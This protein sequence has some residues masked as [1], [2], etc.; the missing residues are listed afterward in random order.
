MKYMNSYYLLVFVIWQPF[1]GAAYS[2]RDRLVLADN[3]W[4]QQLR[5]PDIFPSAEPKYN[6]H[7]NY[8]KF[9]FRRMIK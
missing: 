6:Q 1:V 2:Q 4:R 9:F 8:N 3:I 5:N 7:E